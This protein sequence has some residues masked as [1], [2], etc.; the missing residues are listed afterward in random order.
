[1]PS[2]VLSDA[3]LALAGAARVARPCGLIVLADDA[4]AAMTWFSD[5]GVFRHLGLPRI[6]LESLRTQQRG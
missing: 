5:T 4:I 6:E 1:M 3:A 2:D